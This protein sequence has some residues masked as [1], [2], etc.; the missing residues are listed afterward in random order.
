VVE[1]GLYPCTPS[2]RAL[3]GNQGFEHYKEEKEKARN[4]DT[5]DFRVW[6]RGYESQHKRIVGNLKSQLG[7]IKKGLD[8]TRNEILHLSATPTS[9][10][11]KKRAV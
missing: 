8:N 6:Q 2:Q 5:L 9:E 10:M 7:E 3:I 11:G 1:H 4:E